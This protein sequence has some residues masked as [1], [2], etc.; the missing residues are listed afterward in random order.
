MFFA[1]TTF[2]LIHVA[3][4]LVAIAAGFA[5]LAGLIKNRRL[6]GW[7]AAFLATTALTSVTGFLFPFKG[8]TPG[9]VIG[10]VSMITLGVAIYAL[11]V[12]RLAGWWRPT[13]VV[14][15]VASL[16]FNVFVLIVQSFQK[17]AFLH[18]L[19]PQQSE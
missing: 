5:V 19:A 4:S 3:I 2:V 1:S 12:G 9:I 14:A 18:D 7:T 13:Y 17:V 6:G 16:F 11:Y 15:A 10:V 8:V